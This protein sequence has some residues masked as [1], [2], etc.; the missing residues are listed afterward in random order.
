MLEE[1]K[2]TT[3]MQNQRRAQIRQCTN[4][5]CKTCAEHK[6]TYAKQAQKQEYRAIWQKSQKTV[7]P[8]YCWGLFVTLLA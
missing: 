5:K 7:P 4:E 3:Q 8:H 2:S 1:E 6:C